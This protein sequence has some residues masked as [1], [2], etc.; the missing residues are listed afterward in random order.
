[1]A[2]LDRI[3]LPAIG[4][5]ADDLVSEAKR[6]EEAGIE[7]LWAPELFRSSYTQATWLAANTEEIGVGTGIA[8]AFTRSPFIHAVSALDID[9]SRGGA[10]A[11]ASAPG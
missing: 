11:S 5:S 10:L 9:E 1:M 8:W 4:D 2:A 3:S 7:C 6:A